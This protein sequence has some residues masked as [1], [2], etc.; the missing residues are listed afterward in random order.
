MH[1]TSLPDPCPGPGRVRI[2]AE[3]HDLSTLVVPNPVPDWVDDLPPPNDEFTVGI[4]GVR[5]DGAAEVRAV[6]ERHGWRLNASGKEWLSIEDEIRR[7]ARSTVNVCWYTGVRGV[8]G[9]SSICLASRRPLIINHS[10]MLAHVRGLPGV[11]QVED[12]GK[13]L[14]WALESWQLYGTGRA[15]AAQNIPYTLSWTTAAAKMIAAWEEAR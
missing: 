14:R 2:T 9:A 11:W 7:L 3:P 13:L 1:D 12:L 15:L 5:G 8:A 6:C 10:P 4:T